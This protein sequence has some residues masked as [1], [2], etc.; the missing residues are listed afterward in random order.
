MATETGLDRETT[1]GASAALVTDLRARLAEAEDT[2]RAIR[3][4]EV[5]ALIVQDEQGEGIYTLRSAD[6]PYR[7]LVEQMHEGAVVLSVAG[8]I[9]YCNRRFAELV[10]RPLEEVIGRAFEE[11]VG[12][13]DRAIIGTLAGRGGGSD[14]VR[15]VKA[16]G[17]P[18]DAYVSLTVSVVDSVERRSLIIADLSELLDAQAGRARAERESLAKDEFMAMLAH[19]LRNPLGAIG[20]AV[21]VMSLTGDRDSHTVKAREVI[22]RQVQHLSR[23]ID[24][25]LGAGRVVTGKIHIERRPIDLAQVIG[26]SVAAMTAGGTLSR[27]VEVVVEPVWINGDAVRI[28]QVLGNLLGNSVKYTTRGGH[29]KVSLAPED[30]DAVLRVEDDGDGIDAEL[31]PRVFELFVQGDPSLDRANGGLGIGL[32]LVRRLA[33]LHGG[34][35]SASSPGRGRGS[36]FTVRLPRIEPPKERAIEPEIAHEVVRRRVVVIEDNQDARDMCRLVLE[37]A[38]HDVV[39]ADDGPRGLDLL[40]STQADLALIDIG[41]PNLDGYEVARQ[42]RADPANARTVLVALTGYGSASDRERARRAGFDHHLTKPVSAEAVR[43][44]LTHVKH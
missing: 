8:D 39:E 2:L 14:R 11:F 44:L 17:R 29:I 33:E 5:D 9:L 12:D 21:H 28:E 32:T 27:Q 37:L 42:F 3:E 41:L 22:T 24:D 43:D 19:E 36:T 38:G 13:A 35:V 26:R 16:N 6:Q 10:E 7:A 1:E 30:A 20:S 25:L 4:G 34:R 23:L 31:L 15:L 18:V 40:K